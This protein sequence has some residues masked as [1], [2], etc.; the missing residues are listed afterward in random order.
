MGKFISTQKSKLM[1][2]RSEDSD[3]QG[4]TITLYEVSSVNGETVLELG[5]GGDDGC[6]T[7]QIESKPLT[8]T[9]SE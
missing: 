5:D 3:D 8:F 9:L 4:L 7:L 2:A 1:S 6:G